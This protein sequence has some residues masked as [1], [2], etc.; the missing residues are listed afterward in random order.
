MYIVF[1]G[2][3]AKLHVYYVLLCVHNVKQG[4]HFS[5]AGSKQTHMYN[6]CNQTSPTVLGNPPYLEA[7]DTVET[8]ELLDVSALDIK[9]G[10]MP[11]TPHPPVA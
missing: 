10:A 5:F 6:Y 7:W 2:L 4:L 3:K 11:G 8:R 9:A 1:S